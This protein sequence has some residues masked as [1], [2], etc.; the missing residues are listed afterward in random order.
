MNTKEKEDIERL[1]FKLK[2]KEIEMRSIQQIGKALSS[3]LN[4][5]KLLKLIMDQVTE[6]MQ[7]ERGTLYIV[8]TE[9]GEL[10][11]KIAQKAEIKE[12]R[13]DPAGALGAAGI[14]VNRNEQ[15]CLELIGDLGALLQ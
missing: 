6:L 5:D 7:A 4:R 10:W 14:G 11:S 12:I 3:V 15:V 2:R 9:K 8:D 13:L 1:K